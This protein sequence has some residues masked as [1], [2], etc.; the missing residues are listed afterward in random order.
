M[1]YH[2]LTDVVAKLEFSMSFP[3]KRESRRIIVILNL[4][5][6]LLH[7]MLKQVQHD[8]EKSRFPLSRE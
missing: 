6:D 2:G 3:R 5:Q 7:E 1:S 4:F 8:R